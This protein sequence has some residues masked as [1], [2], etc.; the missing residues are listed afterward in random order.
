MGVDGCDPVLPVDVQQKSPGGAGFTGGSERYWFSGNIQV[1]RSGWVSC[2]LVPP[3]AFKCGQIVG[4]RCTGS[5]VT[6][7][8]KDVCTC[9][10]GSKD[11]TISK[12]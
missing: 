3:I 4:I 11:F 6:T 2:D 1:A 7:G 5:R 9:G 12:V 8:G 10:L